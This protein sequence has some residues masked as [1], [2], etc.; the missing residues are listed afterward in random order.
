MLNF[1]LRG[2][3]NVVPEGMIFVLGDN[4]MNGTDSRLLGYI[5]TNKVIGKV[6][7]LNGIPLDEIK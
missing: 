4:R 5:S 7:A 1:P 3:S 2:E 6:I